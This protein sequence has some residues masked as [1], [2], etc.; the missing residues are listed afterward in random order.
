M[1]RPLTIQ[2]WIHWLETGRGARIVGW[3]A[4]LLGGL[5]LS[6]LVAWKQFEGPVNEA[7]LRQADLGRQLANGEGFSSS[8]NYPQA[9]AYMETRGG[10]FEVDKPMPELY[11]APLYSMVI[12]GSLRLFPESMREAF[13]A[14][15]PM[16]PDGYGG[17]YFLLGST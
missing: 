5:A 7:T 15:A 1:K 2:A 8:V 4:L 12:A 9:H 11:E 10:G 14:H 16:P 13:F 3:S 6:L 17:D